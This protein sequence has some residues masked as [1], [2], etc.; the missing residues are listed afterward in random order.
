MLFLQYKCYFFGVQNKK[1][2]SA[3]YKLL[4]PKGASFAALWHEFCRSTNFC[5]LMAQVLPP[6]GPVLINR[7][8]YKIMDP[9]FFLEGGVKISSRMLLSKKMTELRKRTSVKSVLSIFSF[10]P[11]YYVKFSSMNNRC[12]N[13][14]TCY[15]LS[16]C[17]DYIRG[18]F[19]GQKIRKGGIRSKKTIRTRGQF[20]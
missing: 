12:E 6:Y 9:N 17:Y 16:I 18:R 14:S 4:P 19:E 8:Q 3:Q 13:K 15:L 20:H 10:M 2:S 7:A 1:N 5:R 11:F